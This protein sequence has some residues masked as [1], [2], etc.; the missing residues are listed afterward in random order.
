MIKALQLKEA[1]KESVAPCY[2]VKG[3]DSY[4]AARAQKAFRDLILPDYADFNFSVMNAQS[5]QDV[6]DALMTLPVFDERKVVLVKD[7]GEKIA[8]AGL[9]IIEEYLKAPNPSSV[10]VIVSEGDAFRALEKR[11]ETVDCSKLFESEILGE[12]NA[13]LELPPAR[14]ME[15]NAKHVLIS[16]C[17]GDMSRV[18]NELIKLK[19]FSESVITADDV[20]ELVAPDLETR[21]YELSNALSEK[22]N[23]Q[24]LRVLDSFIQESAKEQGLPLAVFSQLITHYRRL[25]HINLSKEESVEEIAKILGVKSGAVYHLKKIAKNY[26]QIKLKNIVEMLS[27]MQFKIVSESVEPKFA[28]QNAVATLM[29]I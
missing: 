9:R 2:I 28:L 22:N 29:V 24:A 5:P 1:L 14:S 25:L 13:L 8:D 15:E 18:E 3:G 26:S 19:S 12:I 17:G 16:Y 27:E 23:S 4:L 10:L 11:A 20:K 21:I 6:V 7:S